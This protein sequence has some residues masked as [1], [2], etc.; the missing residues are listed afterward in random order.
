[1]AIA[2][3]AAAVVAVY[4]PVMDYQFLA[5][6][7]STHVSENPH[8]ANASFFWKTP[9]QGLYMPITFSL[10]S[11]IHGLVGLTPWAFHLIN[12][13]FHLCSSVLVFFMLRHLLG[14]VAARA[15][16]GQG[17][18]QGISLRDLAAALGALLFALHPVQAEPVS[19]ITSLKDTASG[20][21]SMG[22][23]LLYCLS[24]NAPR[25]KRAGLYAG[26]TLC[27]AAAMLCK[28]LAVSVLLMLAV[29]NGLLFRRPLKQY[30]LDLLPWAL[31]ALPVLAVNVGSQGRLTMYYSTPL[32]WRPLIALDSLS[33]YLWKLF[34]PLELLPAYGRS[35]RL[36]IASGQI[37]WTWIPGLVCVAAVLLARKKMPWLAI[38]FLIFVAGFFLVSGLKYFAAQ[39]N[40]TVY[41]RYLYLSMLGPAYILAALF[42]R[43]RHPALLAAA[44]LV[45]ALLAVKSG[46]Q[47]RHWR[48]DVTLWSYN[49]ERHPKSAV[50]L[51]N[52]GF[53]YHQQGRGEESLPLYQKA[54]RLTPHDPK[55]RN[56]LG[57]ALAAQNRMK[58]AVVQFREA[59]KIEPTNPA[60]RYNLGKYHLQRG[61]LAKAEEHLQAALRKKPRHLDAGLDLGMIYLRQN[62]LQRCEEVASNV[63]RWYPRSAD[64]ATLKGVA[65]ARQG[66]I[67]QAIRNFRH[68]LRL[69]PKNQMARQ[70]L[71]RALRERSGK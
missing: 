36:V 60:A 39:E 22:A 7:D 20:L 61:E 45:L 23:M 26:G 42:Q 21:F 38:G 24:V 56:N 9:Y 65:L 12:L 5:W 17:P 29:F 59:L 27:F 63:M 10:W 6:D 4:S 3:L 44:A 48:D 47:T 55:A 52:L 53:A 40:T 34:L 70:N 51:I 43:K 69:D 58:E 25:S 19:W 30:A 37:Y 67:G 71:A 66:K 32:W 54:V 18:H 62:K 64:A 31:L 46:F 49:V 68:A 1:L 50:A 28:P 13:I 33:F 15:G 41:D 2:V 16:G 8:L 14:V 11:L 57:A 35:A